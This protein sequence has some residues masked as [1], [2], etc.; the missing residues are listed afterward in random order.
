[1][2]L[3]MRD[4]AAII[5]SMGFGAGLMPGAPGTAG[6]ALAL[7]IAWLSY[8]GA[9]WMGLALVTLIV[10]MLGF[11]SC[12]RVERIWAEHDSPKIVIDEM[13]GQLVAF[14][15]LTCSWPHLIVGFGLFRLFDTV[16][17][18][19]AGWI[20]R[21]VKGGAGVMLDDLV[22]GIFACCTTSLLV[23]SGVIEAVLR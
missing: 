5:V 15:P 7:P 9:G 22:A 10:T 6:S 2:K 23:Y 16:K 18:W 4:R 8:R 14:L 21:E 12:R 20:D 11:W 13:A 1:M 17:P 3:I 19:P